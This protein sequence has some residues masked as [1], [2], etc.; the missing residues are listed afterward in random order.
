[1]SGRL[2]LVL[3][4]VDAAGRQAI[5][6]LCGDTMHCVFCTKNDDIY[7]SALQQAEIIFGEP[8]PEELSQVQ[9]LR[10]LQLSWAGAD[11][12][13]PAVRACGHMTLTNASGAFGVTI[14]EH[15]C[16]LLLSLARRLPAYGVQQSR[17]LW[18]DLGPE[19]PLEGRR[20]LILGTGDL[21]SQLAVRLRA[22][23]METVGFCRS[24]AQ[25]RGLFDRYITAD[26][27]DEALGQADAVFGCLPATAETAGLLSAA[28]LCTMKKDAILINV[29]R[30]SLFRTQDLCAALAQGR[31]FGV[32]LDV[33]Q[34]EPLPPDSPLWCAPRV[35]LT[36]HVAGVGVGHSPATAEKILKIFLDNLDRYLHGRPLQNVVDPELGY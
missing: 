12:F 4:P 16:G 36:P 15:A 8:A 33:T 20:A 2:A 32:G 18:Q 14:A 17:R 10:W 21:G 27:L 3:H 23:G 34:E 5:E 28:R 31:F 7:A 26:S 35:I 9:A 1:M 30:G 24:A 11:R 6:A 13:V 29:G 22:F 25:P 19:W